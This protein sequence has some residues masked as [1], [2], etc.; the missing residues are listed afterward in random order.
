MAPQ[1]E[2]GHE[3]TELLLASAKQISQAFWGVRL[4]TPKLVGASS[5]V[6]LA[7]LFSVRKT[8][9]FLSQNSALVLQLK[10]VLQVPVGRPVF[11][12]PGRS[13]PLVVP[14]TVHISTMPSVVARALEG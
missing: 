5:P 13:T 2:V 6:E 12:V 3:Y 11:S 4:H 9:A 14:S 7:H 10:S 8:V 1:S